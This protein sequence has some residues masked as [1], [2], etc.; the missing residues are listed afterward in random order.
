MDG[1]RE[2]T[3]KAHKGETIKAAD[4][5]YLI[6]GHNP[7]VHGAVLTEALSSRFSVQIQVATDYDLARSLKIEPRAITVA[8]NLAA[9][10]SRGE[11]GWAPQLRELIAFGKIAGVLGLEAAV[12][13]L[14]GIAPEEDRDAV[15]DAAARAFGRPVTPLALGR[16]I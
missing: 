5:F 14:T 7:G 3:V 13:N 6:G 8:R 15:A 11:I 4:G 16:Q 9:R 1:R 2:I 10:Q 12:A